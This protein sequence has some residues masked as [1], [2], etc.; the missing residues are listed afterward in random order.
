MYCLPLYE[1]V[2]RLSVVCVRIAQYHTVN[3]LVWVNRHGQELRSGSDQATVHAVIHTC[4]LLCQ[5]L[6]TISQ[7]LLQW[8]SEAPTIAVK[9]G[10]MQNFNVEPAH[11]DSLG[12]LAYMAIVS[13]LA[14]A[15]FSR[16]CSQR[17]AKKQEAKR[18]SDT[19][20]SSLRMPQ[21]VMGASA[22]A[23]ML[24]LSLVNMQCASGLA[25]D[26]YKFVAVSLTLAS[27]CTALAQITQVAFGRFEHDGQMLQQLVQQASNI[28]WLHCA[29]SL[30]DWGLMLTMPYAWS[31]KTQVGATAIVA[32]ALVQCLKHKALDTSWLVRRS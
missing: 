5:E 7:R 26:T 24:R 23:L 1:G 14:S 18:R 25:R 11:L 31:V 30:S 19:S 9:H 8:G 16:Q 29:L 10:K 27:V 4:Q 28:A 22:C 17:R 12:S 21:L 6:S 2:W 15:A 20:S 13:S 3:W 32:F